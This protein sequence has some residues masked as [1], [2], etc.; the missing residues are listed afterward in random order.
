MLGSG[1][2]LLHHARP[3]ILPF[4]GIV[5]WVAHIVSGWVSGWVGV[6][7]GVWMGWRAACVARLIGRVTRSCLGMGLGFVGRLLGEALW[8]A[9]TREAT[10]WTGHQE[11]L[12][13][14][15]R[16]TG[17]KIAADGC[18]SGGAGTGG[19]FFFVQKFSINRRA[20]RHP[21]ESTLG[22]RDQLVLPRTA[23]GASL[24]GHGLS[25]GRHCRAAGIDPP[26]PP[27]VQQPP[28]VYQ[29]DVDRGTSN[30]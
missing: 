15:T 26:P 18:C 4:K 9:G 5:R 27:R 2:V 17:F 1:S 22:A 12:T 23:L 8:I 11:M 21:F 28:C 29:R 25:Q 14:T 20:C 19:L 30:R 10:L 16:R 13:G 24:V 7:M 6:W 3:V